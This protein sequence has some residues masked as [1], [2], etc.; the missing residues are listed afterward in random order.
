MI[1][2]LGD[3]RRHIYMLSF[4]SL[5]PALGQ[6][7]G[8]SRVLRVAPGK[9]AKVSVAGDDAAILLLSRSRWI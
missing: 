9:E 1:V 4:P 7:Q 6:Q 8:H 2:D 3:L 5:T